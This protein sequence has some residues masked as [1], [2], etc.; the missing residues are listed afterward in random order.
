MTASRSGKSGGGCVYLVGAGPGDPELLTLKAHRLIQRAD[1]VVYDRLVSSEI[2]ALIPTGVSRI[3]AGK[4]AAR[5]HMP[6]EKINRMLATLA[7]SGRNVVRLKGG[8]PFVFGRGAEEALYLRAHDIPCEVVPGIGAVSGCSASAGVPLTHRG[9]ASGIRI[10]TG[11]IREDA[12]LNYDWA[13]LA[14][15]DTTLVIYMGLNNIGQI[16]AHLIGAGLSPATPAIAVENA[17]LPGERRCIG[18]VADL[19]GR[20]AAAQFKPPALIIIGKVVALAAQLGTPLLDARTSSARG[21]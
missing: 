6:Q 10:I 18:T 19:P 16:C 14:D 5:H 9:L 17:T 2:L 8:D 12:P 7:R 20:V 3:Y 15:P 1:V 11:H 21:G 13:G 4:A